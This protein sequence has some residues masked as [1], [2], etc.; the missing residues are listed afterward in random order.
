MKKLLIPVVTLLVGAALGYYGGVSSVSSEPETPAETAPKASRKIAEAGDEGVLKAL[1]SRV[2]SLEKELAEARAAK[3]SEEQKVEGEGRHERGER[4]WRNGPNW[5]EIRARMEQFKKDNPEE[6]A[7]M[8]KMRQDFMERRAQ[9]AQS[10][11]DFL[12]SID[13]SVMNQQARETHEALQGLIAKREELEAKMFS[14][15][16]PDEDRQQVFQDMRETDRAIREKNDQERVKLL[17]QTAE[18]LGLSG[19]EATEMVDTI[20]EI[21]EATSNRGWGGPGPGGPMGGFGG[22]GGRGGMGGR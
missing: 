20:G 9:R 15:D 1:R 13:T 17:Q 18:A 22:R 3:P 21:Y 19:A 2:K 6:F 12:S 16:T 10:K 11:I 8:E 14:P 5:S 7:R 4:N